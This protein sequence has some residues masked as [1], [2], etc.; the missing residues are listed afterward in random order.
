MKFFTLFFLT[1]MEYSLPLE[2]RDSVGVNISRTVFQ[3]P[4]L[5]ERKLNQLA[6]ERLVNRMRVQ[7]RQ[8]KADTTSKSLAQ[9][10][11]KEE[12]IA[13]YYLLLLQPYF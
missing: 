1:P 2:F 11:A 12:A 3:M 10:K 4:S 9:I 8:H 5:S 7:T 13:S 6:L